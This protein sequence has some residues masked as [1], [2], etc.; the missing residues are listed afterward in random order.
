M[1]KV[2]VV[3]IA[4]VLCIPVITYAAD[5]QPFQHLQDQINKLTMQL[6]RLTTQVEQMRQHPGPPGPT[7]PIGPTG[8]PGATGETGPQGIPGVANGASTVVYG[9]H[10]P[11]GVEGVE[12]G[13][14][15][16]LLFSRP[17]SHIIQLA[18]MTDLAAP[19]TC[20]VTS[21]DSANSIYINQKRVGYAVTRKGTEL[22][23]WVLWVGVEYEFWEPTAD[24]Y[25]TTYESDAMF[26]FIC[27][28]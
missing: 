10:Y 21:P 11:G 24:S 8:A 26:D 14:N 27:V 28:Q 13:T 4:L 19:P 16:H 2:G 5:G 6:Q 20:V 18:T 1:K 9:T 3:M 25:P 17:G 22:G 23:S 7:G 12:G 15:W